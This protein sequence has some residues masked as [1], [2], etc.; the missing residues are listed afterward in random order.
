M[1][2]YHSFEEGRNP[3]PVDPLPNVDY[4]GLISHFTKDAVVLQNGTTLTAIDSVIFATGYQFLLPFLSRS[5]SP[6]IP[7]ALTVSPSTNYTSDTAPSLQTNTR[8]IYPL[9]QHIFSLSPTHPPAALAFVG[10]PVLIANC[11][12]DIAQS[13]LI[14]HTIA[15]A[16]VLPERKE[17]LSQLLEREESLRQRGYDP[18]IAGHKMVGGDDDAQDYQNELV[19][20]LKRGGTIPDDGK[21][22]VEPWRRLARKDNFLIKRGWTRIEEAGP[23]EVEKWLDGVETE[24]Q[25]ADLLFRLWRWQKKYEEKEGVCVDDLRWRDLH[26]WEAEY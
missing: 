8:Y 20:F 19:R 6:D 18:Y 5:P 10:L 22:Y 17:L 1:Y 9:H 21:D 24:E 26:Y 15:N 14:A 12:S 2:T 4:V 11:P 25:W 23:E 16:S 3:V 13:M 7:V